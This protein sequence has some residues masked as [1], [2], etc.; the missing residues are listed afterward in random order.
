MV[1]TGRAEPVTAVRVAAQA[2]GLDDHLE[3]AVSDVKRGLE[4]LEVE[5]LLA[6]GR[7]VR[8]EYPVT[9]AS[10]GFIVSGYIDL[11]SAASEEIALIDFK[12][13]QPSDDSDDVSRSFP[14]Y[15]AQVRAYAAMVGA[16]RAG[17]LFTASGRLAWIEAR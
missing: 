10:D 14:A 7:V 11:V 5:G 15:A 4:A 2:L 1:V 3:E 16:Q 6:A 9:A 17:L 12:T 13:D 8:L